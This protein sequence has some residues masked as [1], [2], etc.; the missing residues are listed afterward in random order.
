MLVLLSGGGSAMAEFPR[1]GL[2]LADLQRVT[3]DLQRAGADIA[4]L[5]TVRRALSQLKGGGL[6]YNFV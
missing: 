2:G 3:R 4:A 6:S 1:E 5:N